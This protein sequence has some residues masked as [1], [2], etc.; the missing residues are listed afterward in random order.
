[1]NS[2]SGKENSPTEDPRVARSRSKVLEAATELLVEGG[3]RAVT[4]DAVAE[5]SGVAKSTMYRHF[6]SRTELL[7][8]VLRHNMPTLDLEVPEGSFEDAMRVVMSRAVASMDNPDW[9]RMLPALMSL[10][11]TLPDIRELTQADRECR[12]SL[13]RAVLARGIDEG[14]VP[15]DTDPTLIM[16]LLIGPL[17]FAAMNNELD[18]LNEL[19]DAV[20]EQFLASCR[21]RSAPQ[22][23]T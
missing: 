12:L 8:N 7:V 13:L 14:L 15:P 20:T 3:H 19:A 5:R 18:G 10:K 16:N 22:T 6:P 23:A 2:S 1:M 11:N 9:A 21:F 17:M 4:V